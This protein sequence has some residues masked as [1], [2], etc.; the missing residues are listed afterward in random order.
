M[1]RIRLRESRPCLQRPQH[2]GRYRVRLLP[3][4]RDGGCPL[5]YEEFQLDRLLPQRQSPDEGR[6]RRTK[7][8]TG[9]NLRVCRTDESLRLSCRNC[10]DRRL[11]G[12]EV[13][14][15]PSGVRSKKLPP[16]PT[17]T[18]F[19]DLL[20]RRW[21][22]KERSPLGQPVPHRQTL[23]LSLWQLLSSCRRRKFR[24]YSASCIS[25]ISGIFRQSPSE[26]NT[27]NGDPSF[28]LHRLWVPAPSARL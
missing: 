12:G 7:A 15:A 24:G 21:A 5:L 20:T 14:F 10:G 1:L 4:R 2:G 27:T 9:R 13:A 25:L 17:G 26:R 23:A 3:D 16:R 8:R 11:G 6:R 19:P 28:G 22:S 18:S